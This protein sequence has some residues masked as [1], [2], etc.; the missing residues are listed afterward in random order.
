MINYSIIF[1]QTGT[2]DNWRY[3][4]SLK[5][6]LH[7]YEKFKTPPITKSPGHYTKKDWQALIDS[8]WGPGL[9]TSEK[10]AIFDSAFNQIDWWY[11]AFMNLDVDIDS[12]R[13]LYRPE[14]QNGVSRGRFAAIMNYFSMALK[15]AHTMIIDIPVNWGT[16]PQPGISLFVIGTWINN[17]YFGANLTPLPDSSLLVYKALSNHTLGLVEGDIVL[18]Y[19]GVPWKVLY[20]ELLDAQLPILPTWVWGSTDESMTHIFLQSAGLNWHLF[21]T[22]DI[23]KHNT[24]D[25]LHLP[26]SLLASQTGDIWG[27]EQLPVPGVP[28][29]NVFEDDYVSWGIVEGTQIGYI[30]VASWDRDPQLHISQ[31]F[32]Y[33]VDSLMNYNETRGLIIDFR[34][35]YGGWMIVA[36]GGYSLLFNTSVKKVAFDI[37]GDPNNHFYMIP[38]PTFTAELFTIPGNPSSYYDKPIA[39][40]AGPGSVSNGDWE[41]LRM[42]FHPMTRTFGKKTNGAFT[43]SDLPDLGNPDWFFTKA[44]GSGYLLDGH[45]YLAHTSAEI[46]TEVW[47]TQQGVIEGKDDVVEAAIEWINNT[48][49][50]NNNENEIIKNY[51]LDQNFPNPFN[52]ATT[53]KYQIPELSF[54]ALKV[55]DVLGNEIATLVNE[56]KP[57]GTYKIIWNAENLPSGVY[58]YQLKAGSYIDTKKVVLLR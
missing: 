40:L 54:V 8:V 56:E 32:Y 10:L 17:F 49:S 53:I 58:F 20:K 47:L 19:D 48:A 28:M 23:I 15:D 1:S 7:P 50:V 44:T 26:T 33:A 29:P 12:L 14:I 27:N 45:I 37:R 43:S 35:N 41:T 55:F 25:T 34:L 24:G 13:D 31:Q 46:D 18:G 42:K 22:I 36:H 21:D 57:T 2:T 11:G 4:P 3:V 38:H 5:R 30:Y 16:Y 6:D 39:V 51:F 9:P 52:P